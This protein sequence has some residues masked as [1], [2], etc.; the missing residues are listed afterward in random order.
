MHRFRLLHTYSICYVIEYE[1]IFLAPGGFASN[2]I[3]GDKVLP[4]RNRK[5]NGLKDKVGRLYS[6]VN[7]Q[8]EPIFKGKKRNGNMSQ[9]SLK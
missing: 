5:G 1:Q 3:L 6:H 8:K 9:K 7:R 4:D 2:Y